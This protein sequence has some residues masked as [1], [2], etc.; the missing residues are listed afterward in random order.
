MTREKLEEFLYMGC[1]NTNVVS[2]KCMNMKSC[3][4]C[5]QKELAEYEK[6]IRDMVIDELTQEVEFEEKWLFDCYAEMGCRYTRRDV[7]IAFSGIKHFLN[8]LKGE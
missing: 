4:S 5:I 6:Q 2:Q 7:D 8:K 1:E 3:R